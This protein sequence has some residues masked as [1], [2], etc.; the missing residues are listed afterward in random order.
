MVITLPPQ[1]ES[2]LTAVARRQ[3]MSPKRWPS[4]HF[5]MLPEP[6]RVAGA[7]GRVGAG[8]A[9]GRPGLWRITARLG[10]QQ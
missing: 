8:A 9:G 2:A 6:G 7:T 3:G 4:T 10:P 1:L 5:A